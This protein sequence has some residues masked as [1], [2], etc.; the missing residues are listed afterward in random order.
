MRGECSISLFEHAL[1]LSGPTDVLPEQLIGSGKSSCECAQPQ[2]LPGLDADVLLSVAKALQE[3]YPVSLSI[4]LLV[5]SFPT[6]LY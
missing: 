2:S 3:Y 6:A 4:R 5:F 1:P